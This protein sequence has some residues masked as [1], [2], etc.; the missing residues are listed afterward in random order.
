[1]RNTSSR[2]A[3]LAVLLAA[4]SMVFAK[5]I[6]KAEAEKVL[7]AHGGVGAVGQTKD[8]DQAGPL[9]NSTILYYVAKTSGS[10]GNGFLIAPADTDLPPLVAFST[11]NGFDVT[12]KSLVRRFINKDMEIRLNHLWKK[13]RDVSPE[14]QARRDA[15]NAAWE[16]I[17]SGEVRDLR[18]PIKWIPDMRVY[19]LV[20]ST[21]GQRK[22][23][24]KD[25]YSY[26]TPEVADS[27][28]SGEM[29]HTPAGCVATAM[30]QLMRFHKW[31]TAGIGVNYFT[32]KVEEEE[33]ELSTRGGNGNGGA[34][35]WNQMPLN[36]TDGISDSQA[37]QI[38]ALCYDAGVSV[39]MKY[40]EMGSG[41]D[42]RKV[43]DALK[44]TFK[45]SHAVTDYDN[46]DS[47]TNK[48]DFFRKINPNL[49]A[50]MPVIM[51]ILGDAGH[52]VVCDG[53]GYNGQNHYHHLNMGW[54][55]SESAWYALADS[56]VITSNYNFDTISKLIYNINK[57]GKGECIGGRVLDNGSPVEGV[58]IT[59]VG[60]NRTATTDGLGIFGFA[61]V[62]AGD[63]KIRAEKSGLK[64]PVSNV[65]VGSSIDE[66]TTGNASI[67][68]DSTTVGGQ[69][70]ISEQPKSITIPKNGTTTLSVRVKGAGDVSYQ[71]YKGY[72]GN[73]DEPIDG[74][75]NSTY[76]TPRLSKTT[77]YWVQVSNGSQTL[78]S[79]T[80]TVSI[81]G[82]APGT[83]TDP[84][85]NGGFEQGT[86]SW[87]GELKV[88]R[89]GNDTTPAAEG[90]KFSY[91]GGTGKNMTQV[92]HQN[93]T[94]P[95]NAEKATLSLLIQITTQEPNNG[96]AADVLEVIMVGGEGRSRALATFSNL[97]ENTD[98]E[99]REID[100]TQFK[101]QTIAL[102][103]RCKENNGNPTSFSIDNVSVKCE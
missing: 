68:I 27:E 80:A 73:L 34:Y 102:R 101:G 23:G 22:V 77:S 20:T 29:I 84:V 13:H 36:P 56:G 54:D 50:R 4:G 10:R 14:E 94:I 66:G 71:W 42:V 49:D 40:T 33:R 26:F 76:T 95:A 59:L 83:F 5:P 82:S 43:A 86:A 87:K 79:R 45:Y 44:N 30:A 69:L 46:N 47:L 3:T 17:L 100:V 75:T 62:K 39:S 1:M 28:G 53:Y 72:T 78:D 85:K 98:Y 103:F 97:Q 8:K 55:G 88:I 32:C 65:S 24:D 61:G 21:W 48:S 15:N 2:I 64:F 96:K 35:N 19:P 99:L 7:K 41:A 9:S 63:Y 91:F 92:L 90:Q 38:G 93:I 18:E 70:I 12:K 57:T 81:Q 16:A 6:T 67:T 89:N 52:A 11:K 37:Q 58:K 74:A 60:L 25:V 51:G 31:P